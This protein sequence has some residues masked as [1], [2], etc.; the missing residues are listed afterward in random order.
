MTVVVG[1]VTTDHFERASVAELDRA[2]AFEPDQ[3]AVYSVSLPLNLLT[4][5][6]PFAPGRSGAIICIVK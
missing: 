3:C 2:W 4:I 6:T 5:T 1:G